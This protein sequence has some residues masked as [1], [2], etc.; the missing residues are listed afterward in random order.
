MLRCQRFSNGWEWMGLDV[1][2]K[3]GCRQSPIYGNYNK[4]REAGGPHRAV[5]AD[6]SWGVP[7]ILLR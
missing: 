4:W 1:G 3:R 6:D 2:I 5:A 7:R